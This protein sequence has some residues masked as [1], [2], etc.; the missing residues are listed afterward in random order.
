MLGPIRAQRIIK[1]GQ[2]QEGCYAKHSRC[3]TR[4]AA[5]SN[6]FSAILHNQGS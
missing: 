3:L 5:L 1:V 2:S 6:I 4:N